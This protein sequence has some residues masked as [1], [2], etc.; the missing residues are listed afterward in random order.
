MIDWQNDDSEPDWLRSG[1]GKPWHFKVVLL[2]HYCLAK[3]GFFTYNWFRIGS[4]GGEIGRRAS[5]RC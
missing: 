4:R 1:G 5:F 2:I 3:R